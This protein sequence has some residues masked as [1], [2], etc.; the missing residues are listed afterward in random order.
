MKP[1]AAWPHWENL[2]SWLPGRSNSQPVLS[3]GWYFIR[4]MVSTPCMS[5]PPPQTV[6][7][8]LG[9]D[10]VQVRCQAKVVSGWG[11]EASF[12]LAQVYCTQEQL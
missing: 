11:L 6:W 2:F 7:V 10:G 9:L 1:G 5:L 12:D 3:Q 4:P 8:W